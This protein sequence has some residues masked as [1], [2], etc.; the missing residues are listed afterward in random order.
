MRAGDRSLWRSFCTWPPW[1]QYLQ[2]SIQ[3]QGVATPLKPTRACC[4]AGKVLQWITRDLHV[5][6]VDLNTTGIVFEPPVGSF[7]VSKQMHV[8]DRHFMVTELWN[9]VIFLFFFADIYLRL[10]SSFKSTF[11]RWGFSLSVLLQVFQWLRDFAYLKTED[12]TRYS[13][14]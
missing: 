12:D 10:K 11:Y 8:V 6:C 5:T 14:I 4:S 1:A 3:K 2:K 7:V 13:E 9:F